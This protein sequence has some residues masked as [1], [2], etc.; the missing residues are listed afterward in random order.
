M[1]GP[2]P[3][4][5]TIL[6]AGT[7][8]TARARDAVTL[9]FDDRHRRRR[10]YVGQGGLAFLLDLPEAAVLRDGDG[11]LLEGGGIVALHAASEP[12]VEVRAADGQALLRLAWHLGNRH[13]PAEIAADHIL[14]R[15]DHVIMRMLE[16]LGAKLRRVNVP[17]NPTGGAY[18][19]HDRDLHR[20]HGHDAGGH[21]HPAHAPDHD[22]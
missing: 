7:W 13:L 18:G 20:R 1:T 22:H 11:L 2:L 6:P 16:G 8:D 17:F 10:R 14:I 4:A 5:S 9:D 15:D 3:R 19:G 21:R 12:L